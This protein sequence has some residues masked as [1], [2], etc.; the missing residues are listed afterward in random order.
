MHGTTQVIKSIENI[1][2]TEQE[3]ER[4]ISKAKEE[5]DEVLKQGKERI[6]KMKNDTNEEI[7]NVKNKALQKGKAEVEKEVE[8]LLVRAK[9]T[10][11]QLKNSSF[12]T[13][14]LTPILKE[15]L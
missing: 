3:A 14:E 1:R 8:E 6:A 7:V 10:S 11:S 13:K 4:I 15:L 5:A 2:A 12:S 9:Q